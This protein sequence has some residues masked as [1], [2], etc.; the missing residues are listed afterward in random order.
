MFGG[1]KSGSG[2]RRCFF[3]QYEQG[4]TYL[5]ER[6]VIYKARRILGNLEL[7]FLDLLA[8]LPK[9]VRKSVSNE[10]LKGQCSAMLRTYIMHLALVG[11]KA[12]MPME[13]L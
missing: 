4:R 13:G 5:L 8:K 9:D 11:R 6:L 10:C 2:L 7:P 12:N 3:L 1:Q